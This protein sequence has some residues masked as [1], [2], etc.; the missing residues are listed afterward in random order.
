MRNEGGVG[1]QAEAERTALEAKASEQ[2]YQID[3]LKASVRKG[4]DDLRIALTG[5]EAERSALSAKYAHRLGP[6]GAT[7]TA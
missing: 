6:S 7:T 5:S 1:S 3:I 4:D 2:A